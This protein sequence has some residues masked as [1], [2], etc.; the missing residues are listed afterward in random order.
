MQVKY[1]NDT[2]IENRLLSLFKILDEKKRLQVLERIEHINDNNGSPIPPNAKPL[3]WH[4]A[5]MNE[6]RIKFWKDLYRINYFVDTGKDYMVIINWYHKP[7]WRSWADNYNKS[8][9]KKLDTL[10]DLK[11]QEALKIK[12]NYFLNIWNYELLN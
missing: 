9:K 1:Y 7:D 11:I 12:Q 4:E 6:L 5:E 8:K 3:K 2:D 10:I